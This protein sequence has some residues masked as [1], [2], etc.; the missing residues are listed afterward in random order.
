MSAFIAKLRLMDDSSSQD[1]F[2]AEDPRSA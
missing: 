1:I 2:T